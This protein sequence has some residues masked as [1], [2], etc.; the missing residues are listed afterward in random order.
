M[1]AKENSGE[2]DARPG[3]GG[4]VYGN[5]DYES[6]R[7][8]AEYLAFHYPATDDFI[9]LLGEGAPGIEERYPYAVRGFWRAW[10]E[11]MAL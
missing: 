7:T 4:G 2:Q 10:R 11:C 3:L 8:V 9:A 5:T 6:D 1:A